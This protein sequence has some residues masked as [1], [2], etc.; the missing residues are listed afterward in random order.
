MPVSTSPT[1]RHWTNGVLIVVGLL[2]IGVSAWPDP[3]AVDPGLRHMGGSWAV[4][5]GAGALT[6]AALLVGQRWQWRGVAQLLVLAACAVLLRGPAP[7]SFAGVR[8]HSNRPRRR[9]TLAGYRPHRTRRPAYCI[10]SL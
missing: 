2:L 1:A 5:A 10:P 9:V 7:K 3:L 6:I 8:H 4:Y